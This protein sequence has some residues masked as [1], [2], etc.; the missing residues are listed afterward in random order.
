MPG[1]SSESLWL[2]SPTREVRQQAWQA[3]V[4]VVTQIRLCFCGRL[5]FIAGIAGMVGMQDC[6]M[7]GYM[8]PHSMAQLLQQQQHTS[9]QDL[10]L[11]VNLTLIA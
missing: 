3:A 6:A 7:G 10:L 9:N 11:G 8:D 1:A 5:V 2:R 4:A